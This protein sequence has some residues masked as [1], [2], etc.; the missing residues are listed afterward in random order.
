VTDRLIDRA[1][2]PANSGFVCT[3]GVAIDLVAGSVD[4]AYSNQF[5]EHL[6]PDDLTWQ[7]REIHRVLHP[8]GAYLCRAPSRLRGP[9]DISV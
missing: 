3:S 7:L 1:A 8:G 2:A 6:H 5:T 4:L 9:H